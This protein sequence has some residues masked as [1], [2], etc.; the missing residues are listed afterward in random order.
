MSVDILTACK[1]F[2]KALWS[3]FSTAFRGVSR[4][5][6]PTTVVQGNC[7]VCG[8]MRQTKYVAFH[9]NVGMLFQRQTHS[10]KA[11]M[12]RSCVNRSFWEYTYKNLLFGWWGIISVVATPIYFVMNLFVYLTALYK[13][14]NALE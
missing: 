14:R 3:G 9:R 5:L 4:G 10:I 2:P 11:N 7:Q 1:R 8:N 13:L 6:A 12:C